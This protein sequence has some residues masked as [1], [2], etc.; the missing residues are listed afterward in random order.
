[1]D[2]DSLFLTLAE[3]DFFDCIRIERKQKMELLPGKNCGAPLTVE[4]CSIFFPRMCCA[5]QKK[6]MTNESLGCSRN[7][8]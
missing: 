7:T 6:N 2:S 5:K 1:M 3:K 4:A 8:F